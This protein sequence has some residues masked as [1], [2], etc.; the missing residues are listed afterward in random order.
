[1]KMDERKVIA[2]KKFCWLALMGLKVEKSQLL[3]APLLFKGCQWKTL[4][5]RLLANDRDS[6]LLSQARLGFIFNPRRVDHSSEL[7]ITGK[8]CEPLSF[9]SSVNDILAT[10][11]IEIA[12]GIECKWYTIPDFSIII[13]IREW[14][15]LLYIFIANLYKM[16]SSAKQQKCISPSRVDLSSCAENFSCQ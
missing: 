6:L 7:L 15:H 2:C 1:M 12:K 9:S 14:K 4:R 8:L 11:L 13:L 10:K 5:L 3:L 16:H